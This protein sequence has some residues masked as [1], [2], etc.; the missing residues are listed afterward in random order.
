[1]VYMRTTPIIGTRDLRKIYCQGISCN[2]VADDEERIVSMS[3]TSTV[4]MVDLRRQMEGAILDE[5]Q[6]GDNERGWA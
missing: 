4:A 5:I 3:A 1:M 6:I 2:L